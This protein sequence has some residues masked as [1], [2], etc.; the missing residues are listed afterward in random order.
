MRANYSTL[1]WPAPAPARRLPACWQVDSGLKDDLVFGDSNAPRF[2][3]W[4]GRLR[5]VPA[6]PLVRSTRAA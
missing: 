5:P 1:I 3:F 2:V 6:G 4:E